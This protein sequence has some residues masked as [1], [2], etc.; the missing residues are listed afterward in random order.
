[1]LR[2]GARDGGPLLLTAPRPLDL[3]RRATAEGVAT[4]LLVALVV[5]SGIAAERL[6]PG[7]V[8]LQLLENSLATGLGLTALVATFLAASGAH[9]NPVV[10]LVERLHGTRT[11]RDTVA[12]I[13]AQVTGACVG[14]VAANLMF[15]LPAITLSTHHRGSAGL[16]LGEVLATFGL[17]TVI[18]GVVRSGRLDAVPL[19]VGGYIAAAYWWTS[20]TSFANPAVTVGRMLTD[21]FAGIQPGSAPLF[22]VAQ[23][24]GGGLAVAFARFVFPPSEVVDP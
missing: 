16:W 19:A 1:M 9:L 24:V 3:T 12:Y 11:T 7:D 5:G 6:S 17:V 10:T 18:L 13:A 14:A 20:S 22:V 21:T 23:L 2:R 15:D 4:A 8:G